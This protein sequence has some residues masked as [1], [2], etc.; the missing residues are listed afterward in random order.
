MRFVLLLVSVAFTALIA[1]LTILDISRH[2]VSWLD[3]LAL[4]IVLLFGTG[5]IGAL[6]SRPRH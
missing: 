6:L 5:L 4:L 2:G 1:V 3:V